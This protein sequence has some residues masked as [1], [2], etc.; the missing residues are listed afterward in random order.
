MLQVLQCGDQSGPRASEALDDPL[1]AAA[2]AR[3]NDDRHVHAAVT[4]R[5]SV[6]QV[7]SELDLLAPVATNGA[8]A[9]D[10]ESKVGLAAG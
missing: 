3:E 8:R 6:D 7:G 9:I 1:P 2:R 10:D 5:K 4:D